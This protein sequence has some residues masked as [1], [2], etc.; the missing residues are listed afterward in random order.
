MRKEMIKKAVAVSLS[1]VM[2]L[3]LCSCSGKTAQTGEKDGEK[4]VYK[5]GVTQYAD[6]PSLDNCREGFIKGLEDAGLKEGEDFE[7]DYQ[8]AQGD[9][10]TASQIADKFASSGKDLVCGIA[11]PSAQTLYSVC[12]SKKIPVVFNAVSDPIEAG[13]AKDEKTPIEGVTGVSDAL[14]VEDQLK[15][16]REVLPEA[17]KIGILYSTNEANSVSTLKTYEALA[18]KYGFEIVST[19]VTKQAEIASALDVILTKVDCISNMTDNTVVSALSLVLD[20][21]SAKK[22]PVFGSEEE[23]VKNGCVASAGL[24]YVELGKQAGAMAA[25]ILKGEDIKNIP[26]ETMKESKITVNKAAAEKIGLKIGDDVLNKAEN[27]G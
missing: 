13:L 9:I 19:G 3:G 8:S 6:H 10:K 2:A 20:K 22:I 26:F 18:G 12:L 23:Q 7:I 27:V 11:T 4:K 1:A 17:K 16:I 24:D 25:K 15:L 21:A 14:P 5:I